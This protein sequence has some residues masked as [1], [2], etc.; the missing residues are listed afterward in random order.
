MKVIKKHRKPLRL[1]IPVHARDGMAGRNS[2]VITDPESC[3][4]TYLAVKTGRLHRRR[5]VVV[6][7]S[8]VSSVDAEIVTLD[9]TREALADFPDYEM[10]IVK[11]EYKKTAVRH[12]RSFLSLF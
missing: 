12:V 8:L 7:V 6:P 1:G 9:M 4:P 11:G 2:K 5:E 10:T 3:Q